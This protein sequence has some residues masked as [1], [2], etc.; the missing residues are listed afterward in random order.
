MAI[1]KI[2]VDGVTKIDL[3]EDTVAP[4]NVLE[5]ITFHD[6]TG[7]V[8]T[9]TM[10]ASSG[11]EVGDLVLYTKY[12]YNYEEYLSNGGSISLVTSYDEDNIPME[13][14]YVKMRNYDLVSI[15]V[16]PQDLSYTGEQVFVLALRK[17]E[18]VDVTFAGDCGS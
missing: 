5:G 15:D 4:E 7:S 10:T 12:A 2:V 14:W 9:G 1:N 17:I 6:A 11:V 3:T 16:A 13:T 18:Y 8:L